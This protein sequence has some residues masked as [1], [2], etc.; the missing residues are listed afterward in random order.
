M[1]F[2]TTHECSAVNLAIL[3]GQLFDSLHELAR[4]NMETCR[5]VLSGAGLHWEN[6]LR[7]QTPEQLAMRQ[8]ATLPWLAMQF[9]GYTRGW[10]DIA[11]EAAAKLSRSASDSHDGH[12]RHLNTT[13]DGMAR[14]ARGVDS[15]L[16]A[17]HPA[18][19]AVDGDLASQPRAATR[20]AAS[21]GLDS[22]PEAS[23]G[24]IPRSRSPRRRQSSR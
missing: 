8:A 11:S 24:A 16:R 2:A 19:V 20:D 10:M 23:A 3:N 18:P 14:C 9:A 6:V 21:A 15:M 13:L 1:L 17:L 5:L 12:V 7:A 22:A 4:L